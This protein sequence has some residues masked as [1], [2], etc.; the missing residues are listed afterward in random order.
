MAWHWIER[1]EQSFRDIKRI[2]TE[3]SPG[4]LKYY[5]PKMSVKLLDDTCKSGIGAALV[6]VGSPIAYASR[7]LT[8]TE[9]RFAQI[10]KDLLAVTFGCERFRQ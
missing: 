6:Q 5:D 4:L 7:S 10:E 3:T 2:L 1:H 8:E 9:G